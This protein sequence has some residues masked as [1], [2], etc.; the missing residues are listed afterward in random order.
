MVPNKRGTASSLLPDC[1]C[2][3]DT[4]LPVVE[5]AA[6]G[7]GAAALAVIFSCTSYLESEFII[8]IEIV[9]LSVVFYIKE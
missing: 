2:V 8:K 1:A 6:A 3:E 9:Y 7:A 5:R 4:A